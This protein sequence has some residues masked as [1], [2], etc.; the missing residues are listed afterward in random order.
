MIAGCNLI[1]KHNQ[2]PLAF[3]SL[4]FLKQQTADLTLITINMHHQMH[5]L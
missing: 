2:H 4:Q 5:A 3:L 1:A